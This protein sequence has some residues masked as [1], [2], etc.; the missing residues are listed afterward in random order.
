M[1]V[2]KILLILIETI[3]IILLSIYLFYAIV[4]E[5]RPFFVIKVVTLYFIITITYIEF[6][7]IILY[8]LKRIKE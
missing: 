7:D 6:K 3:M 5:H 1:K 4:Y 8:I 2:K